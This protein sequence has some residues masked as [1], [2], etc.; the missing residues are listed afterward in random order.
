LKEKPPK[1][2]GVASFFGMAVAAGGAGDGVPKL[3]PV[4]GV[5]AAVRLEKKDEVAESVLVVNC[6]PAFDG[7]VPPLM[8]N[9]EL[10]N[11]EKGEFLI[12]VAL[13]PVRTLDANG[14]AVGFGAD[15]AGGVDDVKLRAMVGVPRI[16]GLMGVVLL[17]VAAAGAASLAGVTFDCGRGNCGVGEDAGHE[18]P[19]ADKSK[20]LAGGLD[21]VCC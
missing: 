1:A 5:L 19:D 20:T 6:L 8:A 16:P 17:L 3:K 4:T 13:P 18:F 10:A 14:L 11:V 7:V 12:S 15:A 9:G 2:A 21:G